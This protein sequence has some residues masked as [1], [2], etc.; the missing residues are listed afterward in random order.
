MTDI[1]L[2]EPLFGRRKKRKKAG[3][4]WGILLIVGLLLIFFSP[5]LTMSDIVLSG[6]EAEDMQSAEE[7][8]GESIL[9]QI[10]ELDTEELEEYINSLE[11]FSEEGIADRLL[12]YMRGEG[13]D[14]GS[15][16]SQMAG[17]LFGNIRDMLPAFACICA[18]SLLCGILSSVKSNFAD[19][20][21]AD[22]IFLVCYAASLIPV[23]SVLTECFSAAK[24][25]IDSMGRQMRLVFPLLLT[26]MSAGGGSVS[27]AIY[28]PAVA[29]LSTVIVSVVSSVVFPVVLTT[30]AFSVAGNFS[31]ELKLNRFSAFFKS[32]N[33]WIIGVGVSVFG[34]F[35]TAQGLTAATYDGIVRRA[36]KYA[37]GTGVPIVGGFLSGGFD[38]AVAGS[39]LIKNSLGTM[40]IFLLVS[41]LLGPLSLLIAANLF[42]RLTAAVTQPLGES[43]I[44]D[45]LGETADNLNYCIAGLLF[46]AFLYF[47]S[48]VLIICS[49]EVLF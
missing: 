12:G 48:V 15:F 41:V 22:M 23:L 3:R 27:A 44:S 34:L 45:F 28:Q 7:Q 17:I 30:V 18:I 26:L 1:I 35:L 4:K 29:F 40:S 13:M 49:S 38:L 43:R 46:A 9:E 6:A 10:G 37:I 47:I 2:R 33:K 31:S 36:A 8:L 19:P 32:I 42:L 5:F 11:G 21:S 39:I 24:E 16:F 20:S 25:C 14:Y